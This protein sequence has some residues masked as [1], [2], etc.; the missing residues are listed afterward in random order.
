MEQRQVYDPLRRKYVPLTPEEGVRQWFI[1]VLHTDLGIPLGKMDSEV[2]M[3]G[4]TGGQSLHGMDRG[5]EYRADIVVYGRSGKPVV[6][7]ECKRPGV[8]LGRDVVFQAMR[9]DMVLGSRF[10]VLTNG[11]ETLILRRSDVKG[12]GFRR[13]VMLPR[14]EDLR[15]SLETG[16]TPPRGRLLYIHGY[17]GHAEGNSFSMIR[18]HLPE[19]FTIEGLDYDGY[20]PDIV[21][22]QI[23][24]RLGDDHFDMVVGMSLGGFYTLLLEGVRRI[25]INPCYLPSIELPRIGGTEGK[26]LGDKFPRYEALIPKGDREI[27]G[28]FGS[29]DELLG[30][31]YVRAFEEDF[32]TTAHILPCGHHLSE[33]AA[34]ILCEYIGTMLQ[35]PGD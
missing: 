3:T 2:G 22:P 23:R 14:W 33:D 18:R 9:Y 15:D 17:N 32:R 8:P 21:L 28:F 4:T 27:A 13:V 24:R 25:V 35:G 16:S 34:S 19:G 31:R 5:K 26:A 1:S 11:D 7:V 6:I 30:D 20:D 10:L 12:E 29:G